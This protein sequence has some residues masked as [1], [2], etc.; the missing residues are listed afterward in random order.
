[1]TLYLSGKIP[2]VAIEEW[3]LKRRVRKM[4][5]SFHLPCKAEIKMSQKLMTA[6]VRS[7]LI[8]NTEIAKYLNSIRVFSMYTIQ[9]H[10]FTIDMYF[11]NHAIKP[12]ILK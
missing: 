5:D 6:S 9:G 8:N 10:F 3:L 4:N 2:N 11:Y 1:M 7:H 12:R